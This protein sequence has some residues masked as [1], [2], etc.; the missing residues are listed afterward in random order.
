[1]N[2]CESASQRDFRYAIQKKYTQE[3]DD[4]CANMKSINNNFR[5]HRG[6]ISDSKD[7]VPRVLTFID[8]SINEFDLR[9]VTYCNCDRSSESRAMSPRSGRDVA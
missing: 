5:E 7:G 3:F 9:C 1:M 2:A 8:R 4:S 6:K